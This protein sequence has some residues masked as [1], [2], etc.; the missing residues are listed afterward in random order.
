ARTPGDL[1]EGRAALGASLAMDGGSLPIRAK[2]LWGAAWLAYHQ[3][4]Y[5]DAETI[6][7]RLGSLSL[8]TDDPIVRR[9]ALTV[10]GMVAM[11]RARFDE[12]VELFDQAVGLLKPLGQNWLFATSLLNAGSALVQTRNVMRARSALE[13]ARK[14]YEQLGDRQ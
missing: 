6:A 13:D 1:A 11:A 7:Q 2:A 4:D 3:A 8:G 9:N 10:R 5:D 12:A 14:L